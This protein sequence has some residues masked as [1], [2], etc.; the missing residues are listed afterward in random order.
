MVDLARWSTA[1]K[2]PEKPRVRLSEM[3][4]KVSAVDSDDEVVAPSHKLAP[5]K[6]NRPKIDVSSSA[7]ESEHK[8]KRRKSKSDLDSRSSPSASSSGASSVAT[9]QTSPPVRRDLKAALSVPP[10]VVTHT[11]TEEILAAEL[12]AAAED[13]ISSTE[14]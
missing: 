7:D 4:P 11:P 10:S 6:K 2:T 1:T 8:R 13:Q 3:R 5:K 9:G 14:C 12:V